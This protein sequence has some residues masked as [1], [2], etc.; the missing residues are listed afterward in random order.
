MTNTPPELSDYDFLELVAFDAKVDWEGFDYAFEEYP[1]RFESRELQAVADDYSGLK[2]LRAA[3]LEK[4][5]SFWQEDGAMS[6][7]DRH[8]DAADKRR[9]RRK[10]L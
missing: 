5:Q 1:P 3:H 9:S 4:I 2:A 6:R 10:C 7:Y 8:L